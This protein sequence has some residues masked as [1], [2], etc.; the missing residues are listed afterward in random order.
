MSN[1]L[2]KHIRK[3]KARIRREVLDPKEQKEQILKL[4]EKI[5]K[6][7]TAKSSGEAKPASVEATPVKKEK[8]ND[9]KGDI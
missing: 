1:S 7:A 3:E 4:R 2:R 8:E 6:P 9:D 5:N